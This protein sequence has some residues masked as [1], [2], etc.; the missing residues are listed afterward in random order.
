MAPITPESP[1]LLSGDEHVS[2]SGDE[3]M[4]VDSLQKD[5]LQQQAQSMWDIIAEMSTNPNAARAVPP[6][7]TAAAGSD[8]E[9]SSVHSQPILFH[10]YP[11][12]SNLWRQKYREPPPTALYQKLVKKLSKYTFEF[13]GA[14]IDQHNENTIPIERLD[15]ASFLHQ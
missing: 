2:P 3:P 8:A 5:M 11:D 7:A 1:A 4:R 15:L 6:I 12:I 14:G 9:V 10:I 13:R